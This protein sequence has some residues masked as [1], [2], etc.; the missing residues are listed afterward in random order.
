MLIYNMKQ[1]NAR[2]MFVMLVGIPGSGKSYFIQHELK[3]LY[4][5]REFV[6]ISTDNII[7][8]KAAEQNKTYS[9]IWQNEIKAATIEMNNSFKNAIADGKDIVFDQTNT[10]I[11]SRRSKLLQVSNDYYKVAIVLLTPSPTELDRR[12][13]NRP[14]KT[15]PPFVIESMI[16]QLELPTEIEGFDKIITI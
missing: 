8:R 13:K 14:G 16:S 6:I 4:T 1:N 9:E 12:L 10:T 15:I 11:K 7:D 2:K 5:D 3:N